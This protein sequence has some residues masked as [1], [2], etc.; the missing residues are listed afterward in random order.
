MAVNVSCII[1]CFNDA[2]NLPMAVESC[3]MQGDNVEVIIVDDASGD[4][5]FSIAQEIAA[6]SDG[7]VRAF[8]NA[9]NS[10]PAFTR[11][12]GVLY[13]RGA[14]LCFL[15]SDD[16]YLAG[17]V[18]RCASLLAQQ[19]DSAAVKT[20]IEVVDPDGTHRL[21]QS[22]PRLA[23]A[24]GSY[25]CNMVVRKEIFLALGGFPVD[26]RYRGPLGGE[27]DAF[28]RTLTSLFRCHQI[29]QALVRHH[30]RPGSHLENFLARSRVENGKIVFI[31]NDD[32]AFKVQEV[33]A[34]T[35]DYLLQA[36]QNL[37]S[38]THCSLAKI[39]HTPSALH[40]MQTSEP[41]D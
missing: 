14:L 26:A 6:K 25:P 32:P 41:H 36:Q 30:N 15:D 35:Q 27:D 3:L 5:S 11:N 23:A 38:L 16:Q 39:P 31:H 37:A 8:R 1:P 20:L 18:Q 2:K 7:R 9:Q 34:A 21:D 29:P 13:A 4:T 19:P 17:F 40:A 12:H 24:A 10:G 28:F 22:D 33:L